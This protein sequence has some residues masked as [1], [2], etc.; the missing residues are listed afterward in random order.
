MRKRSSMVLYVIASVL[1]WHRPP[2]QV[3]EAISHFSNKSYR[4]VST[5]HSE[6][7]HLHCT[8]RSAVQVSSPAAPRNDIMKVIFSLPYYVSQSISVHQQYTTVLL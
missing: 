8:E 3:C 7:A 1:P 5:V 4:A 2:G 6:I